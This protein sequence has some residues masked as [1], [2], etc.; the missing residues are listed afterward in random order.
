MIPKIIHHIWIDKNNEY[1]LN[2][3]IP[4]NFLK[5]MNSCINIFNRKSGY[6]RILWTGIEMRN[7]IAQHFPQFLTMYDNYPSWIMRCDAFRYFVLYQMGGIYLDADIECLSSFENELNRSKGCLLTEEFLEIFSIINALMAS[8]PGHPFFKYL[9]EQLPVSAAHDDPL[10][11]TG[12]RFL[13]YHYLKFHQKDIITLINNPSIFV[14]PYQLETPNECIK[15][16]CTIKQY[17]IHHLTGTWKSP[18]PDDYI[19]QDLDP[20]IKSFNAVDVPVSS[21]NYVIII[22]LLVILFI[23]ILILHSLYKFR[24]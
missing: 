21:T 3:V 13:T 24:V 11:A 12:P 7:F 17:T 19:N 1:N 18:E 23:S 6:Q 4:P 16:N 22:I 9:I 14:Y 10:Y 2:P 8:K 15:Q 20:V 5:W